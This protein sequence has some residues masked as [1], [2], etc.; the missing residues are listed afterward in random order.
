[1]PH[2]QYATGGAPHLAYAGPRPSG[3]RRT[4]TRRLMRGQEPQRVAAGRDGLRPSQSFRQA[5]HRAV[6]EQHV[7]DV[8]RLRRLARP[9]GGSCPPTVLDHPRAPHSVMA[10]DYAAPVPQ[11][12]PGKRGRW[13]TA[14]RLGRSDL[15]YCFSDRLPDTQVGIFEGG[16]Q[17]RQA[18][19]GCRPYIP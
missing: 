8:R 2:G 12:T 19:H 16:A 18:L 7:E 13:S 4:R 11:S 15:P 1:L 10:G 6:R 17:G 5:V 3:A 9:G 14:D